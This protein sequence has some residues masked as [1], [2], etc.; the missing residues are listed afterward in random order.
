M[1][2]KTQNTCWKS[3]TR[4]CRGIIKD[5]LARSSV[6]KSFRRCKFWV[7][8]PKSGTSKR[9]TQGAPLLNRC[10]ITCREHF[11]DMSTFVSMPL[12]TAKNGF[13]ETRRYRFQTEDV[14][15][16]ENS[17]L[18]GFLSTAG[19]LGALRLDVVLEYISI[20]IWL[21]GSW[22]KYKNNDYLSWCHKIDSLTHG[23]W[24]MI[25][26]LY[27]LFILITGLSGLRLWWLVSL[28]HHTPICEISYLS[29]IS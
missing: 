4:D 26:M 29:L 19:G 21:P 2:Y 7:D 23:F 18:A 10:W 12:W 17:M 6:Y 16:T 5:W 8:L 14:R 27:T 22:P 11:Y 15:T 24:L 1:P 3:A 25:L 20:A 28:F 9:S 13:T